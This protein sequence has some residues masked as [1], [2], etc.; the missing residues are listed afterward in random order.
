MHSGIINFASGIALNIKDIEAKKELLSVIEN[1][2]KIK[3]IQK[4]YEKLDNLNIINKL[5]TSPHLVSLKTNGNPY[6]LFFTR[7]NFVNHCIFID[8]KI[9]Q[10]Y[11][12]PR[13]IICRFEFSEDLFENTVIDGEMIK[14][15]TDNKWVFIMNDVLVYKNE[16]LEKINFLKRLGIL[17]EILNTKFRIDKNDV[18]NMQIKK[19]VTYN[20]IKYL[21][22]D[23]SSKLPYTCRG[24]YFKP[25]FLKFKD[26]IYNFDDSLIKNINKVKYQSDDVFISKKINESENKL[27][28]SVSNL[29]LKSSNSLNSITSCDSDSN[30]LSKKYL[31]EKTEIPDVYN[32]YDTNTNEKKGI[33]CVP[34]LSV[35]KYLFEIFQTINLTNK[36][37]MECE[38]SSYF[39]KWIPVTIV[40]I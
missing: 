39:K 10:G 31:V 13:M 28:I 38:Y 5:N 35:S 33:A 29:S 6:L 27:A 11:F 8:K 23:F 25:L 15:E 16:Y 40:E 37:K 4:H 17:N 21:V 24:L 18:C 19:Y 30:L 36:I 9:Q 20:D 1:L 34:Y 26:V 7:Y 22:E 32:L 14:C 12:V 2:S 3:I